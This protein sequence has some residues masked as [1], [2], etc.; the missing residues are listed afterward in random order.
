MN[1]YIL[2]RSFKTQS[3]QKQ[4]LIYGNENESESDEL[5]IELKEISEKLPLMKRYGQS[6]DQNTSEM[7]TT[8]YVP[9]TMITESNVDMTT[10]ENN[11][12][13]TNS[14]NTMKL[15]EHTTLIDPQHNLFS[16][17]GCEKSNNNYTLLDFITA[18]KSVSKE[19]IVLRD[20]NI[21]I[22]GNMPLVMQPVFQS[23]QKRTLVKQNTSKL[24]MLRKFFSAEQKDSKESVELLPNSE[25]SLLTSPFQAYFP[26]LIKTQEIIKE[27]NGL[28]DIPSLSNLSNLTSTSDKKKKKSLA[29]VL[30]AL[31]IDAELDESF[32]KAIEKSEQLIKL[33][34]TIAK[35]NLSRDAFQLLKRLSTDF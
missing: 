21:N 16:N 7:H 1:E 30:L 11:E 29:I 24:S 27:N 3:N 28:C 35:T 25:F 22:N 34:R 32:F 2:N 13:Q 15:Y 19:K 9:V 6:Y 18:K 17:S 8:N 14:V 23:F 31:A 33:M 5:S 26:G 12:G 4:S 10:F 20:C